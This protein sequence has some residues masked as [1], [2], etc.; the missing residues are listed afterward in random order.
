MSRRSADLAVLGAT[1]HTLDADR[2]RATAVAL[3][4]GTIVAVGDDAEVRAMCDART[5]IVDGTGTVVTPG[6]TD[7]H[8]H[9]VTGMMMTQGV[10]L[11]GC[12]TPGQLRAA[13]AEERRSGGGRARDGWLLGFGLDP[14]ALG[15]SAPHRR[16]IDDVLDGAP[17]LLTLF[18]GHAALA[19]TRALELAGVT[20]PVGFPDSTAQVVCD[21]DGHP[22]G[23]LREEP[24]KSLV[25]RAV[26]EPDA[27]ELAAG[28]RTLMARMNATGLTGG[29]AMDLRDGGLPALRAL[30]E[31]D[32]VT[33]RLRFAPWCQPGTGEEGLR[34]LV[35]LQGTG[36]RLWKVDGVKL[37][38]DGTIDNGTA[39]LHEPDCHGESTRPFWLPPEK[40]ARA[41][42]A[43]AGAGVPTATH[44]I[45][46]AAVSYALDQLAPLGATPSGARHRIEH[47]ETAPD[48]LIRKFAASGVAASMQPSHAQYTLADHS[49]NWSTRLGDERADRAFRCGDLLRAGALLVLGSDWPIAHF[50]AREVL[51]SARLRRPPHE[52]GR[53]PVRPE[54]ALGA[55]E[56][57]H[58]MTVAPAQVAG[59]GDRAGRVRVGH[60]ADLTVFAADPLT[61]PATELADILVRMTV[62]DGRVVH[63]AG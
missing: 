56:A 49:D 1:V 55:A 52:P 24:A 39:W 19:S 20:G 35:A 17:A 50:D 45:G 7:G 26:P 47:I 44:A 29:H 51:A 33:M 48:E 46:D 58:A 36:G 40:Y 9:P 14:N 37:F 5:R 38:M 42:R 53:V 30:E 41:V 28:L 15:G 2:P 31:Q 63:E 43:L 12:R 61:V 6:L 62:V 4:G 3:R 60:R 34:E 8:I 16:L 10:D 59:E 57:L 21:P 22:T 25:E 11:S 18:D 54:Q 32:A 13:L 23:E 27:D